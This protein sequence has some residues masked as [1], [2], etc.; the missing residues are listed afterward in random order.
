MRILTLLLIA[1]LA[2]CANQTPG[3]TAATN[4]N[5]AGSPLKVADVALENGAPQVAARA[6]EG[7]LTADPRNTAALIR[8]AK[9]Q[10]ALGNFPAAET[11][12]QRALAIDGHLDE[13]RLG[14]AKIWLKTDP[15]RAEKALLEVLDSDSHNTAALNNLGV[16]RDL[17]GKHGEAQEAY[18]RALE[19]QPSLASARENLGLSLAL[20]GKPQEGVQMLNQVAQEDGP[21]NR[22]ARD[23]WAVALTLTGHTVEAGQ[24]L[25]EELSK[26][27]VSKALAGYQALQPAA[28]PAPPSTA[29]PATATQ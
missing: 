29:P 4:P 23:N 10:Q 14:L 11:S 3:Q 28:A 15:L 13:A 6:M 1:T 7:M 18:R 25:Q 26:P 22:Q 8:L 9:A 24:V 19:V 5:M 12:Y 21:T 2:G 27:D 17:Q 20:S 16:A